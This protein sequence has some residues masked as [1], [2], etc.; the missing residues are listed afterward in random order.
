MCIRDR[1]GH[2]PVQEAHIGSGIILLRVGKRHRA[3]VAR[4][5]LLGDFRPQKLAHQVFFDGERIPYL[6]YV[7]NSLS[8]SGPIGKLITIDIPVSY[9]H[10][11]VYKRQIVSRFRC[12]PLHKVEYRELN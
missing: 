12:S 3:P 7:I 1:D 8:Q 10:L 11:D 2:H 6:E 9:T 5:L 4:L